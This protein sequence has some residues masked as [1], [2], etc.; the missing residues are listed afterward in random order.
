V[1]MFGAIS[2]EKSIRIKDKIQHTLTIPCKFAQAYKDLVGFSLSEKAEALDKLIEYNA[3]DPIHTQSEALDKIPELG[4]VIAQT[5]KLLSMP[6][7]SRTYG[8]W[9]KKESIGRRT[10]T[11]YL[12]EFE[13]KRKVSH[14]EEADEQQVHE[15]LAL[16][17]S[18]VQADVFWDEIVELIYHEDPKEYVYD[19]TVPGNDSFMVDNNIM[20]HNTLNKV[21]LRT[22]D[23]C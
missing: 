8:R 15:N 21:L 9:V 6:G 12:G 19:F 14:L 13:A 20:V 1:G 2:T 23:C 11:R 4:H 17:R 5:G 16:L 3:R 22:G 18:A 7:Q 10:L